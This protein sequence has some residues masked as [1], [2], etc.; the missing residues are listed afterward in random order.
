MVIWIFSSGYEASW[1][2]SWYAYD[3]GK[4]NVFGNV[5]RHFVIHLLKKNGFIILSDSLYIVLKIGQNLRLGPVL[6]NHSQI[7]EGSWDAERN[8]NNEN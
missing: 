5:V 2:H 1:C 8:K 6:K 4:K 7:W 3:S